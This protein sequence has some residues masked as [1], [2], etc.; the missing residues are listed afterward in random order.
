MTIGG[1]GGPDRQRQAQFGLLPLSCVAQ[2]KRTRPLQDFRV[3]SPR[4]R[5]ETDE[6]RAAH[7]SCVYFLSGEARASL[8]VRRRRRRRERKNCNEK[9]S[10]NRRDSLPAGRPTIGFPTRPPP[11]ATLEHFTRRAGLL[12]ALECRLVTWQLVTNLLGQKR[13]QARNELEEVNLV[14]F[15]FLLIT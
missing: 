4:G 1:D 14:A 2:Q 5:V 15:L 7:I 9:R 13:A 11:L 8:L 12:R 6:A 10:F 3:S